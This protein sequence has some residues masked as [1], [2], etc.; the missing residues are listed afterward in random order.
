[1][2]IERSQND[3]GFGKVKPILIQVNAFRENCSQDGAIRLRYNC[4][5]NSVLI[6]VSLSNV[7]VQC[8]GGFSCCLFETL[9]SSLT[10]NAPAYHL[11]PV[12]NM[13][14]HVASLLNLRP[15][16]PASQVEPAP[17]GGF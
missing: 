11:I 17:P 1:M 10:N 15:A 7:H 2:G 8:K 4:I 13:K 12:K 14:L 5:F 9:N 16:K 6:H 3:G